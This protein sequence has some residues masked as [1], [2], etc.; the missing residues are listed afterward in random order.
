[1]PLSIEYRGKLAGAAAAIKTQLQAAQQSAAVTITAVEHSDDPADQLALKNANAELSLLSGAA[2]LVSAGVG[3]Q[4]SKDDTL[5]VEVRAAARAHPFHDG[6]D[7]EVYFHLDASVRTY[8]EP[9]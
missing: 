4:M 1:M 2:T 6:T 7:Q 3:A 8:R 5:C 9:T